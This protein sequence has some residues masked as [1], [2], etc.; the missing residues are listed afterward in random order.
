MLF[1]NFMKIRTALFLGMVLGASSLAL[2]AADNPAQAAA[3]AALEKHLSRP[4]VPQSVSPPATNPT[5]GI[6]TENAGQTTAAVNES[7]ADTAIAPQPILVTTTPTV[8]PAAATPAVAGPTA[9]AVP[10]VPPV[11]IE[12][13]AAEPVAPKPAAVKPAAVAPAPAAPPAAKTVAAKPAVVAPIV[14][15]P[16]TVKSATASPASVAAVA[17][18]PAPAAR[19]VSTPILTFLLLLLLFVALGL[20][21]FLLLKLRAMKL[22]MQKHPAALAHAAATRPAEPP[23]AAAPTPLARIV[24]ALNEVKSAAAAAVTSE[25]TPD[26][27][28]TKR[29]TSRRRRASH[30]NG[31]EADGAPS[32]LSLPAAKAERRRSN[33]GATRRRES[34]DA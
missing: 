7:D 21:S 15:K 5:A 10:A 1:E 29:S 17:L 11:S 27:T 9:V 14:V 23:V 18:K 22:L 3:R 19:G 16:A 20:I 30:L 6:E 13:A 28:M 34:S 4:S 25:P 33:G 31:T 24:A 32:K 2:R 26:P 8:A 12:L